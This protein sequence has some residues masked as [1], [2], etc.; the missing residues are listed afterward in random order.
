M[1]ITI[2][3]DSINQGKEIRD[4]WGHQERIFHHR[5]WACYP[6]QILAQSLVQLVATENNHLKQRKLAHRQVIIKKRLTGAISCVDEVALSINTS[7]VLVFLW[8]QLSTHIH[9]ISKHSVNHKMSTV[10]K[11]SYP[12]LKRVAGWSL[13]V[14]NIFTENH[15]VVVSHAFV[16]LFFLLWRNHEIVHCRQC[17]HKP[18]SGGNVEWSEPYIWGKLLWF[19]VAAQATDDLNLKHSIRFDCLV[20]KSKPCW[21]LLR[22]KPVFPFLRFQTLWQEHLG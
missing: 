17:I 4:L 3:C 6:D 20:A 7:L 18:L 9:F 15:S 16:C 2:T 19:G 14:V 11:E 1:T 10:M 8:L 12:F 22:R 21:V 5:C 13:V